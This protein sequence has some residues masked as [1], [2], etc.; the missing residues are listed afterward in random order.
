M[1]HDVDGKD[2]TLTIHLLSMYLDTTNIVVHVF[3]LCFLLST[4]Y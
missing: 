3:L 1:A 2:K 4:A